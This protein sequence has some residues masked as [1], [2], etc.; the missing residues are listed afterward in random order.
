MQAALHPH[1]S[2]Q[3]DDATV[4]G[5]P[6]RPFDR[7]AWRGRIHTWAFAAAIPA[8]L[9]LVGSAERSIE[10]VAAAIYA[11]ALVVMFGTSAAYHR[12]TSTWTSRA[13]MRRL[14]H[15]MIYVL[16][17]GTYAPFCLVVLPSSSGMPILTVVT[18]AAVVGI[19]LKTVAFDRASW[20]SY[21]LYPAMVSVA[22]AA[23]PVL[24][25]HLAVGQLVLVAGGTLAYGIG[26]LVLLTR[27]P[28]PAPD[29]F[30]YHE[31]WHVFTVVAAAMHFVAIADVVT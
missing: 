18:A 26:A 7:P 25:R 29:R 8:G 13:I 28:D 10:R 21:G 4:P 22:V 9:L 2:G 15:S 16:V 23:G 1:G 31:V 24:V 11:F 20:W 12:L 19:T 5:A 14:D 30:G 17:A 3:L 27:R 6:T